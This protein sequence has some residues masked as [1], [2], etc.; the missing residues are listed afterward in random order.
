MAMQ[1]APL[2]ST[3]MVTAI[4]GILISTIWIYP[5]SQP[6]GLAFGLAFGVMFIASMLSM[7]YGPVE[8]E[9]KMDAPRPVSK[10]KKR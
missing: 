5:N 6:W 9:L 2:N 3:F 8:A 1:V 4:L 7:T 10:R